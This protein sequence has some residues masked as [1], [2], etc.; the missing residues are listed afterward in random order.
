MGHG[1]DRIGFTEKG[2]PWRLGR[3]AREGR[4]LLRLDVDGIHRLGRI[5]C[6]EVFKRGE[7]KV[8]RGKRYPGIN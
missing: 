7:Q 5:V 2:S 4:N 6:V 1:R 8:L 3:S